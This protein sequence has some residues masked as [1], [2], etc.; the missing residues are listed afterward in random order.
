MN[1]EEE[2]VGELGGDLL[3]ELADG[4][5]S[6]LVVEPLVGVV[7]AQDAPAQR[8]RPRVRRC[9]PRLQPSP[10]LHLQVGRVRGGNLDGGGEG[11]GLVDEGDDVADD[12]RLPHEEA[13]DAS[14]GVLEAVEDHLR[15]R[16]RLHLHLPRHRHP[17]PNE[18][19]PSLVVQTTIFWT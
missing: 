9:A 8:R 15:V 18:T 16:H 2:G 7:D 13:G 1:G 17:D 10:P 6:R 12:A 11:E 14:E 3:A 5:G 4:E 19:R